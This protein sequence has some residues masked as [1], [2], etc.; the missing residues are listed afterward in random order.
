MQFYDLANILDYLS[1]LQE[2]ARI[3]IERKHQMLYRKYNKTIGFDADS[4]VRTIWDE[5]RDSG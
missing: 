3:L 2:D 5:F 4:I 1:C